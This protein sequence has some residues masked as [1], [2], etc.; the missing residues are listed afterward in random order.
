MSDLDSA[1]ERARE[2]LEG[3]GGFTVRKMFGGAGL[4]MDGVIFG[5]LVSGELMVKADPKNP[6]A[7]GLIADLEAAGAERWTYEMTNR[8]GAMPY[9]KLPPDALDDP[10]AATEWARRA[11]AVVHGSA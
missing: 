6:A 8:S 10:D 1:I 5:V 3:L 7:A 11:I 9:W 4:Y 2:L